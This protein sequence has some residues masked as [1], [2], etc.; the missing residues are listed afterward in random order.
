MTNIT[1]ILLAAGKSTRFGSNKL[2]HV[3][4]NGKPVVLQA[5]ENLTKV[6]T[7]NIAV[8][9]NNSTELIDLLSSPNLT[10]INNSQAD[11][12]MGSSIACAINKLNKSGACLIALADMPFIKT[13]TMLKVIKTLEN[14]KCIIAP[15]YNGQRGHPVLFSHHF[16][17]ELAELNTDKGARVVIK[18]N[19][20]YLTLIEVDDA[21]ILK[22]I[23]TT[24]DLD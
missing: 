22:D 15:V 1:G 8:I 2:L 11:N 9:N 7:E 4:N 18:N 20:E 14:R 24:S 17:P 10:V 23:D 12:G 6:C 13:D 16:F 19:T 21:G 5:A 3:L